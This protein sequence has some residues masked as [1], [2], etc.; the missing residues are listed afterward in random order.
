MLIPAVLNDIFKGWYLLRFLPISLFIWHFFQICLTWCPVHFPCTS[1][2]EN[3]STQHHIPA[4]GKI[5]FLYFHVTYHSA[6]HF[7]LVTLQLY[8]SI[9][10]EIVLSV[11]KLEFFKIYL[12]F[13]LVLLTSQ[14]PLNLINIISLFP[15]IKKTKHVYN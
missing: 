1:L 6:V 14:D 13:F 11:S 3:I 7:Q 2:Q 10:N 5:S 15:I 4:L 9:L 8:C 12:F